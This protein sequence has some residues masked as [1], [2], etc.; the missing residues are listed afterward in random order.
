MNTS[1]TRPHIPI[2]VTLGTFPRATDVLRTANSG[3]VL[4]QFWE[5]QDIKYLHFLEILSATH[6]IKNSEQSCAE[7]TIYRCS[8]RAS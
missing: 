6:Y 5:T 8:A 4:K 2:Y 7:D 3:S 1:P